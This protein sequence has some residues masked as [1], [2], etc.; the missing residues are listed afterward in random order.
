MGFTIETYSNYDG[1]L[2]IIDDYVQVKFNNKTQY[3]F[4]NYSG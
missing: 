1:F 2:Q 3:C 4:N